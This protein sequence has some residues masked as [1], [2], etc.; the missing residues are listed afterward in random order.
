MDNL[1]NIPRNINGT[2]AANLPRPNCRTGRE[3][4]C[5]RCGKKIYKMKC[6][7]KQEGHNYCSTKC[8]NETQFK[9]ATNK[10]VTF[11]SNCGRNFVSQKFSDGRWQKYCSIK[12][13]TEQHAYKPKNGRYVKCLYCGKKVYA[14]PSREKQ[15]REKFCSQDCANAYK[16]AQNTFLVRCL[17][18]GK[19]LREVN[20]KLIRVKVGFFCDR[21][22]CKK[23]LRFRNSPTWKGGWYLDAGGHYHI[24]VGEKTYKGINQGIYKWRS[25]VQVELE[26]NCVLFRYNGVLHIN[27]DGS[28]DRIENLYVCESMSE[29]R[30]IKGGTLNYP[31]KSNM[32]SFKVFISPPL[33]YNRY[34]N[35]LIKEFTKDS[36]E[37][38]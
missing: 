6:H 17:Y 13:A 2:F 18:C 22:C 15:G 4:I 34:P 25:R 10:K 28:D 35:E 37:G 31:I 5:A 20:S 29:L 38:T 32:N 23:Y 8:W 9:N 30:K 12:C 19:E 27:E 26:L 21:Q 24:R 11:C 33:N 7:L 16:T 1:L 36:F 3:I 14:C